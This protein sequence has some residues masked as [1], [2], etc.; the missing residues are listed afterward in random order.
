MKYLTE[1]ELRRLNLGKMLILNNKIIIIDEPVADLDVSTC[2]IVI[3]L[4][5]LIDYESFIECSKIKENS[6]MCMSTPQKFS[7]EQMRESIVYFIF[8]YY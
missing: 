7:V 4:F 1:S 2:E 5:I 8:R 3:S 6:Y